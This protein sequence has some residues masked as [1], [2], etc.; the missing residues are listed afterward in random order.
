MGDDD[1][2]VI[3]YSRNKLEKLLTEKL[4][5]K[6]IFDEAMN[7]AK[8]GIPTYVLNDSKPVVIGGTMRIP[9][10]KRLLLSYFSSNITLPMIFES[11]NE[12]FT[13]LIQT[14]NMDESAASGCC[15]YQIAK[16]INLKFD[17]PFKMDG[18]TSLKLE[19]AKSISKSAESKI[20]ANENAKKVVILR[21][22]IEGQ[23]YEHQHDIDS[24]RSHLNEADK[25]IVGKL[26]WLK[27]HKN[28]TYDKY[29]EC[30]E[31]VNEYKFLNSVDVYVI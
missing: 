25:Q 2:A 8:H 11:S 17:D 24:I 12:D 27:E 10:L 14:L 19:E 3:N 30:I 21:N 18:N 23:L 7:E 31:E 22:E 26:K 29:N 15:V 16:S 1:D 20:R 28:E 4:N 6:K 9:L 13:G 5:V